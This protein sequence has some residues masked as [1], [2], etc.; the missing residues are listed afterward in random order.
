MDSG[1]V[2]EY[3]RVFDREQELDDILEAIAAAGR[4]DEA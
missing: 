2:R 1:R 3:F 4:R